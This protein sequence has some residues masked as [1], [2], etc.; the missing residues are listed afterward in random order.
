MCLRTIAGLL[1]IYLFVLLIT[2]VSG[3][4]WF[5]TWKSL[6]RRL[7][8]AGGGASSS[9]GISSLT[10]GSACAVG[11]YFLSVLLYT[12]HLLSYASVSLRTSTYAPSSRHVEK[13]RRVCM[14][15]V[16]GEDTKERF[17]SSAPGQKGW[18]SL[19]DCRHATY[20]CVY[21]RVCMDVF[22]YIFQSRSVCTPR[23]VFTCVCVV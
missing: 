1:Q 13:G 21:L 16:C 5:S 8:G 15:Q 4:S 23:G 17:A 7:A 12:I 10:A 3:L 14:W 9:H 11:L 20:P 6:E 19:Y 18:E 22:M 2:A